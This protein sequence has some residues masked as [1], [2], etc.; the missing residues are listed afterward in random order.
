M[1]FLCGPNKLHIWFKAATLDDSDYL[2][3][4]MKSFAN[5]K[6]TRQTSNESKAIFGT[7]AI[8][9]AA[10]FQKSNAIQVLLEEEVRSRTDSPLTIK[11]SLLPAAAGIQLSSG[12]DCLHL[13]IARGNFDQ[14]RIIL[15]FCALNPQKTVIGNID[16]DNISHL[17]LLCYFPL[18]KQIEDLIKQ[19]SILSEF[20]ICIKG[21]GA[22]HIC[23]QLGRWDTIRVFVQLCS[24]FSQLVEYLYI[25]VVATHDRKTIFDYLNEVIDFEKCESS[26]KAKDICK[27]MVNTLL[28]HAIKFMQNDMKKYGLQLSEFYKVHDE[29]IE[30]VLEELDFN[31]FGNNYKEEI[32]D[33]SEKVE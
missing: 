15:Q 25:Q 20:S 7:A 8:H 30:T 23:C 11:T 28:P 16:D 13:A 6:D 12:Q 1:R 2:K 4:N 5:R 31:T 3:Q 10:I 19:Q 22:I 26:L 24:Q 14:V 27:E 21:K 32:Q 9:I 29:N 18:Q 17:M 33:K